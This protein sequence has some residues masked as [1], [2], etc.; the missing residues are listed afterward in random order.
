MLDWKL[1]D[2]FCVKCRKSIRGSSGSSRS[3]CSCGETVI[4]DGNNL[5]FILLCW[6]VR[7]KIAT[8]ETGKFY[9]RSGSKSNK[10]KF[11]RK[12]RPDSIEPQKGWWN[13]WKD[14]DVHFRH[15]SQIQNL[16]IH[17]I[18]R[19]VFKL[20][21]VIYQVELLRLSACSESEPYSK[22]ILS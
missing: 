9:L 5:E 1:R 12:M 15:Q 18:T 7:Q 4:C 13:F 8:P 11:F 10:V 14:L 20:R 17:H 3:R 22:T 19:P 2:R 21:Q 6:N 16:V